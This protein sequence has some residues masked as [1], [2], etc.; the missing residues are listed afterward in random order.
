MPEMSLKNQPHDVYISIALRCISSSSRTSV[1]R[2]LREVVLFD[3]VQRV[4]ERHVA[5]AVMMS[6]RFAVGGDVDELVVGALRV[7]R[8]AEAFGEELTAREQALE[9]DGTRDRTV[10]EEDRNG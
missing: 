7:E 3:V 4:G 6:V 10:V 2:A 8:S 9:R 5:V 1:V